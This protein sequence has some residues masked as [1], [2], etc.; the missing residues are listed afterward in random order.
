VELALYLVACEALANVGKYAHATKASVRVVHADGVAIVEVADDG[1]GG[2]DD[3]SG[4]GLRGL[5]DRV[6]TLGGHL[7]VAS[8]PGE[9]T[10]VT[11]E[12][13]VAS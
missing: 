1:V 8:P 4:S 6:E 2:A 7:H 5:A 9:G 12:L 11:A 13:P 10:T 3:A